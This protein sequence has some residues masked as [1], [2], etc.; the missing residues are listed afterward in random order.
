LTEAEQEGV[1]H[2]LALNANWTRSGIVNAVTRIAEKSTTYDPA[3]EL[4]RFGG[5][6]LD[7]PAK[8]L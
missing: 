5:Q 3:V 7:L 8:A 2:Q 1:L 6:V 4:E